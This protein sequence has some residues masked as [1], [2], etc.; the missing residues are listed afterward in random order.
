M[1]SE[2]PGRATETN[3]YSNSSF[4]LAKQDQFWLDG[5]TPRDISF[6]FLPLT[7]SAR[8]LQ[9]HLRK[10]APILL[11][12]ILVFVKDA[13][14]LF[15]P[16]AIWNHRLFVHLA[17]QLIWRCP[18]AR[19]PKGSV[20][21]MNVSLSQRVAQGW[22]IKLISCPSNIGKIHCSGCARC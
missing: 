19:N 13:S 7:W 8:T 21:R 15:F 10:A 12:Q 11:K 5:E 20:R 14:L 1:Y 6:G 16:L 22:Q 17:L 3:D 2:H 4:T 9:D 18:R